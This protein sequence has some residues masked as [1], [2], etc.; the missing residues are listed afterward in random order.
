MHL[1]TAALTLAIGLAA[2]GLPAPARADMMSTCAPEI[3]QFCSGVSQGRGRV[4]SCLIGYSS[5]LGS[6]C[7]T[8]VQAAAQQSSRNP[9]VP[10]GARQ[11]LG[12]GNAPALPAA[13]SAEAASLCPGA[14]MP[15]ACIYAN[16]NR[17]SQACSAAMRTALN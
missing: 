15:V 7:N 11:M 16:D 8:Q 14:S 1:A 6:A 5:Q 9:L 17:V 13:C 12:S 10:S 3:G 4:M 2:G